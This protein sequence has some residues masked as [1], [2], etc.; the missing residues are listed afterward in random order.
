[1]LLATLVTQTQLPDTCVHL[2]SSAAP[3]TV[4]PGSRMSCWLH[5]AWPVTL[6][7]VGRWQPGNPYVTEPDARLRAPVSLLPS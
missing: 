2:V 4:C 7:Q 1:M 5:S 6:L 3:A